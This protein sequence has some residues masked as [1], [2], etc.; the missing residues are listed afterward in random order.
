MLNLLS[1]ALK[2]TPPGGR[3]T[4]FAFQAPDG[5]ISFGVRDTGVG[6][7]EDDQARVFEHFGQGRHDV[8]TADKGTGL[9]LAIVK[10]LVEAHGG[11]VS[12]TSH[13]GQGTT[14]SLHMP[15]ER[16]GARLKIAS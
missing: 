9:G 4:V 6:I 3:I 12:L 11:S 10:G 5:A 14:V 16:T 13:V 1:N 8:V 7:G 15:P 2:F